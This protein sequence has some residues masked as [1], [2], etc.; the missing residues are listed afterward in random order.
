MLHARA[1]SRHDEQGVHHTD[2][3]QSVL[4]H[5]PSTDLDSVLFAAL[6]THLLQG[7]RCRSNSRWA[8][9]SR[10]YIQPP[11]HQQLVREQRL[12]YTAHHQGIPDTAPPV[13]LQSRQLYLVVA[14]HLPKLYSLATFSDMSRMDEAVP[15][16]GDQE[17]GNIIAK[18]KNLW[19]PRQSAVIEGTEYSKKQT[20]IRLGLVS[21]GASPR[22][23]LIHLKIPQVEGIA[24]CNT[25]SGLSAS[26]NSLIQG[27]QKCIAQVR[28]D[29]PM[30]I[31]SDKDM[32]TKSSAELTD[33]LKEV[34]LIVRILRLKTIL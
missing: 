31:H 24:M 5:I 26:A 23:M 2:T 20:I 29:L 10:L 9:N 18:L 30:S 19:T 34:A 3:W 14:D 28:L 6:T 32:N 33:E 8:V 17:L 7:L 12:V 16:E 13:Q 11:D 27:I 4:I 25:P 1:R 15:V 22:G 21:V